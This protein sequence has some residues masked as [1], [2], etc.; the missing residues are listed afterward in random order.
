M[1]QQPSSKSMT[2]SQREWD[3]MV[4]RCLNPNCSNVCP[5]SSDSCAGLCQHFRYHPTCGACHIAPNEP[6][7]NQSQEENVQ[8]PCSHNTLHPF[9]CPCRLLVCLAIHPPKC[10]PLSSPT[11][12][13]VASAMPMAHVNHT[14]SNT[15][16]HKVR[17]IIHLLRHCPVIIMI[18][19]FLV[20]NLLH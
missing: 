12:L 2:H 17:L 15:I 3:I 16:V 19:H 9:Q 7:I 13:L 10:H 20:Q 1:M 8:R 14:Q 6:S 18:V 5:F 11:H 4:C